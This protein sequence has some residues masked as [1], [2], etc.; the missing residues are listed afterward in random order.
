MGANENSMKSTRL[1]TAVLYHRFRISD[2]KQNFFSLAHNSKNMLHHFMWKMHQ[3]C[4]DAQFNQQMNLFSLRR[5][6]KSIV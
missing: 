6:F 2:Y 5:G 4:G 1:L 3:I